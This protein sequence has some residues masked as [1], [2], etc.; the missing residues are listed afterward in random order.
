GNV[1]ADGTGH[2]DPWL[3]GIARRLGL[4]LEPSSVAHAGLT[5]A[6]AAAGPALVVVPGS[7]RGCL[8]LLRSSGGGLRVLAPD[9]RLRRVGTRALARALAAPLERPVAEQTTALL[10]RLALP[11]SARARAAAALVAERLA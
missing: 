9:G 6:L 11:P 3:H 8:A 1:A 2:A 5:D 7:E 4:D 10:E